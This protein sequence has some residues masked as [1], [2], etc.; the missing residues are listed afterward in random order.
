MKVGSSRVITPRRGTKP[1]PS[2][3]SVG[4]SSRSYQLLFIYVAVTAGRRGLYVYVR[5]ETHTYAASAPA[6]K[7]R[8]IF[9]FAPSVAVARARQQNSGLVKSR[10]RLSLGSRCQR[11]YV[12]CTGAPGSSSG[13]SIFLAFSPACPSPLTVSIFSHSNVLCS[14]LAF[15]I[16]FLRSPGTRERTLPAER[17]PLLLFVFF[18]P[19]LSLSPLPRR[20]WPCGA[21]RRW[22]T[23]V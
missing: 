4:S 6:H 2:S 21:S 15:S 13:A 11:N 17:R 19:S 23:L 10:L 20:V 1:T 7:L 14:S 8:A 18:P 9:A 12:V 22:V 3:S 5:S 16:R